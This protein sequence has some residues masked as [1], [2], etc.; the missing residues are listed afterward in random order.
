V[1][2]AGTQE[3]VEVETRIAAAAETVFA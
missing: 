3:V 2:E 1:A